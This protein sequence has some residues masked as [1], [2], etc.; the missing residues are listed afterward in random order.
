MKIEIDEQYHV[1]LREVYNPVIIRDEAG[2]GV[3]VCERDGRIE[4]LH[5][6]AAQPQE[7]GSAGLQSTTGQV[8]Q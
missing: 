2:R 8:T 5:V 4:V 1:V 7:Q 6:D 3:A